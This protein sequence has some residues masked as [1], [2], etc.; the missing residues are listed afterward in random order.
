MNYAKSAALLLIVSLAIFFTGCSDSDSK[1]S[2]PVIPPSYTTLKGTV[3]APETV[4]SSLLATVLDRTDS[5]VRNAFKTP[6]VYVN[7][8]QIASFTVD[9]SATTWPLR[10]YNVPEAADGKYRV[11]IVIG[12]LVL[13]SQVRSSDRE[14]FTVSL[15]TTAAAL[16]AEGLGREQNEIIASFPAIV[17]GLKGELV[18]A[19][20]RTALE[21]GSNLVQSPMIVTALNRYKGYVAAIGDLNSTA[22][23]A[24]VQKDNDLDGDGQKDLMIAQ[25]AG[26]QRIRFYTALATATSLFENAATMDSYSDQALLQDFAAGNTS[27]VNTYSAADKD[28]ATGLFFKR[29]AAADLYLKLLVR[30]ID[31]DTEGVFKGVVVEYGFVATQTTAVT[32][33][34]R[35]LLIQNGT[36]VEGAV[37][38]TDFTTDGF[39]SD[40][41]LT[42]ISTLSGIGCYS[43]NQ[44][45]VAVVDGKP[46]LANLSSAPK[47]LAG[48]Y[49]ANTS[50]AL[51]DLRPGRTLEIGDVFAAYFST[52]RNYALFKIRQFDASSI[53]VDYKVNTTPDEPRF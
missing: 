26:G 35:T 16:L 32:S 53:T 37:A 46:E 21:L 39:P 1:S 41:N 24:Y 7:G 5:T 9:S 31:L 40:N 12:R 47:Y 42:Y 3:A 4:E 29:S 27:E 34:T 17:N 15:E 18:A 52:G 28:F 8:Y 14:N 25:V 13:K 11:D 20:N 10:V 19:V 50:D 51:E 36:P 49:F 22:R 43:G 44:M 48:V 45:M 38:A 23:L 30:R 33:G 6:L 2:G